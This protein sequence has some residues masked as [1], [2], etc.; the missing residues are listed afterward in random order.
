MDKDK[1]KVSVIEM[2]NLVIKQGLQTIKTRL[3]KLCGSESA[4][5]LDA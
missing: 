2:F 5:H 4:R 3:S 1:I